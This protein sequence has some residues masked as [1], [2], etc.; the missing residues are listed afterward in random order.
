MMINDRLDVERML[1]APVVALERAPCTALEYNCC[2]CSR[3]RWCCDQPAAATV[4]AECVG[5]HVLPA[6]IRR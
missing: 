5:D 1:E 4:D 6:H 3:R 2:G